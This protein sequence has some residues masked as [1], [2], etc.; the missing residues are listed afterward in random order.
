MKLGYN[1]L[2]YPLE[3]IDLANNKI[4]NTI[5]AHSYY[6]AKK[7]LFFK[8]ALKNSDILLPDGIGIVWAENFL[9]GNIIKKIA[10]YD[11]FIFIMQKL[12]QDNATVFFLGSSDDTLIKIKNKCKNDFPNVK[13]AA[14]S[15][16]YKSVFNK[17]DSK[18]MCDAVNAINPDVL[19]VG[20]TAPKQEKW[21]NQYKNQLH[22]QNICSI[23]AVFDFYSGNIKRSSDFWITLGLEWFPRLI[24]EP[25]RLFYRNFVSMPLFILDVLLIKIFGKSIL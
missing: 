15:P 12:N 24:K 6:I 20:M 7:D 23:G 10:G 19:F 22:V 8:K 13:F 5:N 9:H 14:Y 4:I 21:V 18:A 11:F 1:V 3:S 2:D 17:T 16:P 25:R